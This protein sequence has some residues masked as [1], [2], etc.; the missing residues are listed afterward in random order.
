MKQIHI[1][2]LLTI[3]YLSLTAGVPAG[4]ST[5]L[6]FWIVSESIKADLSRPSYLGA[7]PAILIYVYMYSFATRASYRNREVHTL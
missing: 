7:V 4:L 3:T 6:L 1:G 2:T 5:L